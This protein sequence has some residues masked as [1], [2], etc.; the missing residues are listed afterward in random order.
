[1]QGYECFLHLHSYGVYNIRRAALRL[2][3]V[4]F[5]AT[6]NYHYLR[7]GRACTAKL[8]SKDTY[9]ILCISFLPMLDECPCCEAVRVGTMTRYCPAPR[10]QLWLR[11]QT[12]LAHIYHSNAHTY[13]DTGWRCRLFQT[14]PDAGVL[15]PPYLRALSL[16]LATG[17]DVYPQ[18]QLRHLQLG[19]SSSSPSVLGLSRPTITRI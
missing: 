19:P 18:R 5:W 9:I 12:A 6:I 2:R 16:A 3:S 7:L 11:S 15:L 4:P 14:N 8:Q 10:L 1:V 13:S 17:Q